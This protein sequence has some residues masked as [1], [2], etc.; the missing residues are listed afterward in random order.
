MFSLARILQT[1]ESMCVMYTQWPN[2]ARVGVC[3]CVGGVCVCVCVCVRAHVF[4]C[5]CVCA[6]VCVC[7]FESACVR[8][9]SL[10]AVSQFA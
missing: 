9:G 7:A 4:V 10:S 3:V 1:A 8:C 2:I 5:A 6:C